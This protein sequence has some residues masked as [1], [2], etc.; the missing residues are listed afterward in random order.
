MEQPYYIY[1][2]NLPIDG[3]CEKASKT[4]DERQYVL[5]TNAGKQVS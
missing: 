2:K 4:Y 5:D 3:S 1:Y